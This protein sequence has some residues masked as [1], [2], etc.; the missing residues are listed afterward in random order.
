MDEKVKECFSAHTLTH[1]LFGLGLGLLLAALIASLANVWIGVGVM[2]VA[3]LI[4]W[5]QK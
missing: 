4:D 3:L 2:V 1:S 5:M